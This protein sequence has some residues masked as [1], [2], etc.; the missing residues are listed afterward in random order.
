[1]NTV[2]LVL[3]LGL[4]LLI[5]YMIVKYTFGLSKA[6]DTNVILVPKPLSLSKS[7]PVATSQ[8]IKKFWTD[9]AGSTLLFFINPS[10]NDRTALY[11]NGNEYATAI[12]IGSKLKLTILTAPDAGRSDEYVPA[13]L[14]I[15]VKLPT[16]SSTQKEVVEL[17][18][19][20][21]QK[22]TSVA[23]VKQGARFKIYING[24]LTAAYTCINGMPDSSLTDG[25]IIGD[26]SGR[27]GGTLTYMI[28]YSVP[29]STSDINSLITQQSD[30]DGK[31][32]S[33]GPSAS[34]LSDIFTNFPNLQCPGGLCTQ[35]K[36][37]YPY[38]MWT[39]SY[40]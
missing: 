19:I 30:A 29:L 31:P 15:T 17:Y 27:L 11:G 18:T 21:L 5:V 8:Q 14:Q 9:P 2:Y 28:L 34:S 12:D 35:P 33:I 16:G 36:K 10:I 1:M 24:K 26:S 40:A 4:V 25:L 39:T 20:P 6:V 3:G 32:Y 22:W 37:P 23:I 38:E 7:T 13:E